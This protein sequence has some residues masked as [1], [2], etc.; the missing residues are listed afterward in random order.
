M[1]LTT[2]QPASIPALI[3]L[4]FGLVEYSKR[5]GLKGNALRLASLAIGLALATAYQ[6]RA[7][8]TFQ[9]TIDLLFFSLAAG[10]AASGI[11]DFANARLPAA[12]PSPA[13]EDD[14]PR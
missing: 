3:L 7:N 9:T 10:L 5:L 11:Y 14:K 1:D 8:P 12:T 13:N 4:I 6:L 2:F